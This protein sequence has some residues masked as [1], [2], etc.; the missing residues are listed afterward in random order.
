MPR[1]ASSGMCSLDGA[2][3]GAGTTR[4]PEPW[5]CCQA[6]RSISPSVLHSSTATP[7]SRISI[8]SVC[9]CPHGPA[10]KRPRLSKDPGNL[11]SDRRPLRAAGRL[12]PVL[13]FPASHQ[14]SRASRLVFPAKSRTQPTHRSCRRRRPHECRHGLR[15]PAAALACVVITWVRKTP[16]DTRA[17]PSISGTP[18]DS[19]KKTQARTAI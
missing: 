10:M 14:D 13:G 17:M 7:V 6:P 11:Q 15:G 9:P 3:S 2:R 4:N 16:V 8:S 12:P 5:R 1:S 19:S 18:K